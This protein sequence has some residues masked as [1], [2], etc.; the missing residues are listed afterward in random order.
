LAVVTVLVSLAVAMVVP[1]ALARAPAFNN[2]SL[3]GSYGFQ[4]PRWTSDSTQNAQVIIGVMTFDGVGNV[5]GSFTV[6]SAGTVTTGTLSGTYAVNANGTGSTSFRTSD[7]GGATLA[8][9]IDAASKNLQLLQT[10]CTSGPCV[11]NY[12]ASGT[13]VAQALSS[14]SKASIKGGFGFLISKWTPDPAQLAQS[15]LGIATFDGLG[16]VKVSETVNQAGTVVTV[17]L[18]GS[19]SVNSDCTGS[20]ALKDLKGNEYDGVSVAIA[21]G[22]GLLLMDTKKPCGSSCGNIVT[23]GTATHQ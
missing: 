15:V 9:A 1:M 6:N 5:R 10:K 16:N 19:Y 11:G 18:S 21:S 7:G 12:V 3:K 17:K 22:K 14:C 23:S 8:L 13:A 20:Y 4:L 2:G